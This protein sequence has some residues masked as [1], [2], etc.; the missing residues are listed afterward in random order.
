MHS[1]SLLELDDVSEKQAL[2]AVVSGIV[3]V[4]SIVLSDGMERWSLEDRACDGGGG[5]S[6]LKHLKVVAFG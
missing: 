6:S 2:G 5:V 1:V 3:V 4:V